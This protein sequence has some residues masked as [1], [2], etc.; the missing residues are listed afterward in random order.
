MAK[1]NQRWYS[2]KQ[3][4]EYLDWRVSTVYNYCYQGLIPYHKSG[5]GKHSKTMFDIEEIN[6]WLKKPDKP[7]P[8]QRSTDTPKQ[9]SKPIDMVE[10]KLKQAIALLQEVLEERQGH[11]IKDSLFDI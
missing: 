5:N 2:V 9:A 1:R 10:A 6:E 4:A 7:E 8:K 3:L 11:K